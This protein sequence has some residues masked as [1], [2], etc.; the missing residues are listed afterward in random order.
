MKR[1][2][3]VTLLAAGSA[4]GLRAAD[5]EFRSVV[6]AISGEFH[7]RPMHIPLF[8]LVNVV[9]FVAHPAGAKHVDLAIFQNLDQH[10]RVGQN[11]LVSL[12]HAV[13]LEWKPFF[14]ARFICPRYQGSQV[15]DIP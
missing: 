8:G 13:G 11:V 4:L 15:W 12:R 5:R 2:A 1:A 10:T 6:D 3:L 7:T 14:Q 9:T